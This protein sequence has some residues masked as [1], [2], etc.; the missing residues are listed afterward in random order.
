MDDRCA[1]CGAKKP[2]VGEITLAS[3]MGWRLL[4]RPT[5]PSTGDAGAGGVNLVFE[6]FCPTC[7]PKRKL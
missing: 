7:A 5:D 3:K 1:S 4:R 2:E 6:W